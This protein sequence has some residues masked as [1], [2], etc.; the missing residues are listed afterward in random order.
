MPRN[1]NWYLL[2]IKEAADRIADYISGVD[3]NDFLDH[4]MMKAAVV[5]EIEIIGEAAYRVSQAFKDA[6][7]EIPWKDM[8]H[9]RNFYIHVYDRIKYEKVWTTANNKIPESPPPSQPCS[10]PRRQNSAHHS[11]PSS[12]SNR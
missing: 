9:L 10:R 11:A 12:A 3:R 2:D 5:R 1:D 6:H 8:A 7:L 4:N